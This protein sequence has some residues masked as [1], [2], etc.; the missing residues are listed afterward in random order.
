MHSAVIPAEAGIQWIQIVLDPGFH[1]GDDQNSILSQ[2]LTLRRLHSLAFGFGTSA[3]AQDRASLPLDG[4]LRRPRH[5]TLL[6]ST[7]HFSPHTNP[8]SSDKCKRTHLHS[9]KISPGFDHT[10][11]TLTG[12]GR[13]E[14]LVVRKAG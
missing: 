7:V 1:R 13:F 8:T 14:A 3:Y 9:L 6:T 11:E 12:A 4:L 10:E 2:L 5:H